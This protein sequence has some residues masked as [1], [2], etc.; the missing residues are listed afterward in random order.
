MRYDE[1]ALDELRRL[2]EEKY[3]TGRAIVATRRTAGLRL[4]ILQKGRDTNERKAALLTVATWAQ[5]VAVVAI[6]LMVVLGWRLAVN[7]LERSGVRV[8]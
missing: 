8:V 5:L 6:G 4:K 2:V 7:R 1:A 3:W